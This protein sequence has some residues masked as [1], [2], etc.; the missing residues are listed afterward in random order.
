VPSIPNTIVLVYESCHGGWC[1]KKLVPFLK[2][3]NNKKFAPTLIGLGERS[4]LLNQKINL[5]THIKDVV[6]VFEF[7]P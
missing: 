1:W 3:D 2:R 4:H 5:S 6:Q 7:R